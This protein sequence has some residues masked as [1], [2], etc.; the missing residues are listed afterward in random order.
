[1]ETQGTRTALSKIDPTTSTLQSITT[2]LFPFHRWKKP[3]TDGEIRV[4]GEKE[5]K[6]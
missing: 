5:E 4:A 3:N 2:I 6:K 1:V